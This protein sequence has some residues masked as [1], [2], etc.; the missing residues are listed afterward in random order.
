MKTFHVILL[1]YGSPENLDDMG[2]FLT[3][4]RGGKALPPPAVEAFRKRYEEAGGPSPLNRITREQG[5]AL[6]RELQ[7]RGLYVKTS[8]GMAHCAPWID[9][10]VLAAAGTAEHVI[11]LPMA[12]HQSRLSTGKYQRFFRDSCNRHGVTSLSTIDY[13]YDQPA[14]IFYYAEELSRLR[15]E[16]GQ[17]TPVIFTAHS[18]P[19]S[20]LAEKDPYPSHLTDQ[21]QKISQ[22]IGLSSSTFAYQ[23]RGM[24]KE[25]WLGPS[26]EE[27]VE[28][29]RGRTKDLI[30]C[31]IGFIC[32]HIEILYDIDCDLAKRAADWNIRIHRT[33]SPNTDPGFIKGLAD[34]VQEHIKTLA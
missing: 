31:P 2:D 32:D 13:F 3:H 12:A 10:A 25:V 9:E 11:G 19:E 17:N 28:T 22:K 6:E 1:A 15:R 20:I 30:L 4:I 21:V 33:R 8:V 5:L 26:V 16:L 34:A 14:I 7:T 18:L 29:F 23:S 24:G 27:V